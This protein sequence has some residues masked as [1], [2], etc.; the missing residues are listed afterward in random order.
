M[1]GR[2]ARGMLI[3]LASLAISMSI[4]T[5]LRGQ[6]DEDCLYEYVEAP[7]EPYCIGQ[8]CG[9]LGDPHH[10]VIHNDPEPHCDCVPNLP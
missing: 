9:L 1:K 6:E 5:Q 4:Q 8:L 10:C 7:G 2:L 3:I